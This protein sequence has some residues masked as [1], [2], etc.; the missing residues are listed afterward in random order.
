MSS[1]K[2]PDFIIKEEYAKIKTNIP[3]VN[4]SL[5]G[6]WQLQYGQWGSETSTGKYA[7]V[8]MTKI[9][10]YPRFAFA[11]YNKKTK[12]FVGAGGGTYTFDG[13]KLIENVEY[14]SWG[15]PEFPIAEF[16]ITLNPNGFIQKGWDNKLT[17]TWTRL[18]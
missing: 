18:K 4:S 17:E 11:W 6:V 16:S 7:N 9:Y 2:Y 13:Q 1:E 14:Y 10:A 15:K 5:E 12:S 8:T 3:L